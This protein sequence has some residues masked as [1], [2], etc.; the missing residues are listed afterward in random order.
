M[1]GRSLLLVGFDE[2]YMNHIAAKAIDKG[3]VGE[4]KVAEATQES[5]ANAMK[6]V[7]K[8]NL[9]IAKGM[10]ETADFLRLILKYN[11]KELITGGKDGFLSHCEVL[12]KG[13]W[14]L[15]KEKPLLLTDTGLNIAPNAEE[16]V[17]I[18]KN[19]IDFMRRALGVKR[20]V[21]SILTASGKYN[22]AVKSSVDGQHVIESLKDENAEIRLD[23]VDTAIDIAARRAKKLGGGLADILLVPDIESGQIGYKFGTKKA[24]YDAIGFLCGTTVPVA[25]SSRADSARSKLQSIKYAVKMLE[26]ARGM[27]K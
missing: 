11:D 9:I 13:K 18:V 23:Q 8:N 12:I 17:R 2:Y 14:S 1:S 26:F 3:L 7:D 19:A 4:I 16:K 10:V 25:L 21:V 6:F 5:F 24:G 22:P 20:P 27:Q 15:R